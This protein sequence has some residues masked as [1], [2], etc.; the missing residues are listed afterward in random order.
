MERPAERHG[1]TGGVATSPT[2]ESLGSARQGTNDFGET[3]YRGPCPPTGDGPH[4]YRFTLYALDAELDVEAGA[5]V[6]AV[7]NAVENATVAKAQM[8]GEY[9]R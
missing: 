4:T 7:T 1:D 8:T 5:N 3:G 6:D 2:V 9:E